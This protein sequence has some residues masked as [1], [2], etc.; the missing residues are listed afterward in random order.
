M[1][2]SSASMCARDLNVLVIS[3]ETTLAV[4]WPLPAGPWREGWGA[5]ERADL[6][7]RHP[8]TGDGRSRRPRW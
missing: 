6:R 8:E 2:P 1:T 7:D 5:I 3:A 4:R